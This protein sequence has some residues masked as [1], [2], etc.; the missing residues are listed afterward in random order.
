MKNSYSIDQRNLI[1]EENLYRIEEMMRRNASKLRKACLDED[2]VFQQLVLRLIRAVDSYA[3][4]KGDLD[5]HITAQLRY[6]LMEM[7]RPGG[8]A[9]RT[10]VVSSLRGRKVIPFALLREDTATYEMEAA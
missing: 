4:D 8:L 7:G 5:I 1:V 2:D 10:A 3:P 9:E 6:E